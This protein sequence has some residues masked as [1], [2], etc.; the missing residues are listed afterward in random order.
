ML[1]H[2]GPVQLLLHRKVQADENGVRHCVRRADGNQRYNMS[3]INHCNRPCRLD[4][5]RLVA[6]WMSSVRNVLFNASGIAGRK[7]MPGK[8]Q[9][10]PLVGCY[11]CCIFTGRIAVRQ[12]ENENGHFAAGSVSCGQDF[13]ALEATCMLRSRLRKV[14]MLDSLSLILRCLI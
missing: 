8:G 13:P 1:G 11:N 6:F 10:Q 7:K 14:V 3:Y 5:C 4:T 2:H 9:E 12:K